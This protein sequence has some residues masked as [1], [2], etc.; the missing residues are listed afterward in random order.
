[1]KD[2]A[3]SRKRSQSG[4][5]QQ[6]AACVQTWKQILAGGMN[7]E[8]PEPVVNN[9]WRHLLIQ[10]LELINGNSILGRVTNGNG[11]IATLL[12]QKL[13][14]EQ[15]VTELYLWSLARHPTSDEI[16]V[17]CDYITSYGERRF[18]PT[19]SARYGA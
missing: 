10:N 11:R 17:G 18:R 8:T 13:T 16:K 14:D 19:T 1:M 4:Y 9:A 5:A 12:K 2:A 6:R 3:S 7:L 15:L